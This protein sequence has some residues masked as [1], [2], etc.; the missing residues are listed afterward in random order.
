MVTGDMLFLPH[1]FVSSCPVDTFLID[2]TGTLNGN[3]YQY[4][5]V[6]IASIRFDRRGRL[7]IRFCTGLS[8]LVPLCLTIIPIVSRLYGLSRLFSYISHSQCAVLKQDSVQ[9]F[10]PLPDTPSGEPPTCSPARLVRLFA[11]LSVIVSRRSPE[12]YA[13]IV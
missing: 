1:F 11:Y 4:I 5:C 6:Y 13:R 8:H 9:P 2:C 3:Q 10:S 12:P 7:R